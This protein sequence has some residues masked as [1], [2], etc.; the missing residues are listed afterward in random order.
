MRRPHSRRKTAIHGSIRMRGAGELRLLGVVLMAA[1]L[2][3]LF[4]C[5]PGWAW[6]ALIGAGL[7]IL[8]W[9]LVKPGRH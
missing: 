6:A 4:L 3:L 1:G 5:I 2:V 7:V 9:G 8:G